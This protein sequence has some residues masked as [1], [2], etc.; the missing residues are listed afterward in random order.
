MYRHF[1][2]EQV[3]QYEHLPVATSFAAGVEI[4]CGYVDNFFEFDA[5][6][7]THGLY[8]TESLWEEQQHKLLTAYKTSSFTGISVSKDLKQVY[9]NKQYTIFE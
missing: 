9:K 1:S 2:H 4:F 3:L 7:I 8:R 5:V 6:P